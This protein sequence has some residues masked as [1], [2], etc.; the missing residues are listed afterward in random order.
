MRPEPV[1]SATFSGMGIVG[2]VLIA[3][4]VLVWAFII[5]AAFTNYALIALVVLPNQVVD[6]TD[7]WSSDGRV[8]PM[9]VVHV[10]P[11]VQRLG[12]GRL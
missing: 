11:G 12:P 7:G 2:G 9:M 1:V 3:L 8:V 5:L 4:G 6:T 10:E